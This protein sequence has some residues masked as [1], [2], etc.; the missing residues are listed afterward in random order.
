M[1]KKLQD[2][3]TTRQD[4]SFGTIKQKKEVLAIFAKSFSKKI[5]EF[6]GKKAFCFNLKD[7]ERATE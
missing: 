4:V 2:C 7:F 5:T 1:R 3:L 6:E